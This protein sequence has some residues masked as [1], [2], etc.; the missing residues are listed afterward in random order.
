M[1]IRKKKNK[2]GVISVQIIEK[3]SGK[4][5]YIK[6]I[7][8]SSDKEIIDSLYKEGK[9]WIEKRGGQTEIDFLDDRKQ[10]AKFISNIQEINVVGTELLLGRVFK[11]IGFDKVQ[12][13]M[14]KHLYLKK[15]FDL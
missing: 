3:K 15:L 2:S 4:Y 14:F 12:E 5:K 7:G 1:F 10:T 9:E 11:E 13:S 8:S 6:T